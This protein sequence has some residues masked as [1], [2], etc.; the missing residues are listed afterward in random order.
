M[1]YGIDPVFLFE[2]TARKLRARIAAPS[3]RE[4]IR[5]YKMDFSYFSLLFLP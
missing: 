1:D 4:F 3:V 2:L 5:P